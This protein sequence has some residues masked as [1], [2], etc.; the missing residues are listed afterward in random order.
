MLTPGAVVFVNLPEESTQRV[1]HA[2]KVLQNS[3]SGLVIRCDEPGLPLFPERPIRLYY[4]VKQKFMQQPAR[5]E[6]ATVEDREQVQ[7]LAQ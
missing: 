4:E 2:A 6:A 1:L 7:P 3:P 5:I